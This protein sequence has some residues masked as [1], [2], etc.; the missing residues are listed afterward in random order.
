MKTKSLILTALL[1]VAGT[2]GLMAQSSNVY[3]QNIVGYISQSYKQGYQLTACHFKG[4]PNNQIS[5]M[6]PTAPDG[7]FVYKFKKGIGGYTVDSFV[8]GAWEGDDASML[9]SPGDG[10]WV[11]APSAFTNTFV[12]EIQLGSTNTIGNG[13]TILSSVIPQAGKL[14]TDLKFTPKEG[15]FIFQLKPTG[16]YKVND[17]ADGA[18]EGDDGGNEPTISVGESFWVYS[19][20]ASGAHTNWSRD[21]IVGP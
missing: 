3:S 15:D 17:L 5:T 13:Y 6:I 14:Q 2:A 19:N 11:Y 1:T 21:F 16:G 20:P 12:G 4:S 9:L 7:T 8:D 18:W 10:F